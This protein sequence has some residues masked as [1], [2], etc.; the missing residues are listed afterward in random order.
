MEYLIQLRGT[1]TTDAQ[2]KGIRDRFVEVGAAAKD[3]GK[4]SAEGVGAGA[5]GKSGAGAA[6][7]GAAVGKIAKVGA[8]GLVALGLTAVKMSNTFQTEMLK[9][10]TEGGA[11]AK[12]FNNMRAGVLN[13]AKTGQSFGQGPTSLAQ[14]LYHLE[15]MG[16]RGSRALLGLKLASEEAAISGASLEDTTTSLGGAL[17][18]AAKGTNGLKGTMGALNAI[19]GSGNMRFQEL[20]EA[21]GT[22]LLGSAK[23]AGVSL[24]E[25]GAALAVLTDSGYKASSA[26]AQLGTALHYLYSPTKKA[27]G[28]LE[29]IHLSGNKLAADLHK[30]QGILAALADLRTHMAGMS[31]IQQADILNSI[32]P[33]GRGRVLLNLYQL[34]GRLQPKYNQIVGTQNTFPQHGVEQLQNPAT[35]LAIAWAKVQAEM[36]QLGDSL[37]KYVMPTVLAF[38]ATL[39]KLVVGLTAVFGWFVKGSPA[40]KAVLTAIIMLTA[41]ITAFTLA[42]KIATIAQAAFDAVMDA[43]PIMLVVIAL[44]AVAAGVVYAYNK[45]K[46]FR[47]FVNGI[48]GTISK[49]WKGVTGFFSTLAKSAASIF[50]S[51][52]NGIISAINWVIRALNKIHVSIPGWVPGIGGDSFGFNI[53]QITPIGQGA[54]GQ[55]AKTHG[56]TTGSKAVQGGHRLAGAPVTRQF[57]K[58]PAQTANTHNGPLV[59]HGDIVIKARENELGRVTRRQLHKAMMS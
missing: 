1:A 25:I 53:G 58:A 24:Q 33:G 28:A 30:P 18:I 51:M 12:E 22:G 32:L 13:L 17:F 8:V 16:I 56:T 37:K 2:L 46:W 26:G 38:V 42:T 40:A 21:L 11:T 14:G 7:M 19:A 59:V 6:S 23:T 44:A 54:G 57:T 29:S 35:K 55:N 45:F 41:G 39:A 47:D 34:Q 31:Q 4:A 15:S 50:T 49:A 27:E 20:N 5:G 10:R 36:V 3:A 43:N 9:I 48:P 52:V